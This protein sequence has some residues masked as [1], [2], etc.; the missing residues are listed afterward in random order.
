MLPRSQ[1]S[2]SWGRAFKKLGISSHTSLSQSDWLESR[3]RTW[4]SRRDWLV[5]NWFSTWLSCRDW[6]VESRFHMWLL[7]SPW[8]IGWQ[9]ILYVTVT[10]RPGLVEN[11]LAEK[12]DYYCPRRHAIYSSWSRYSTVTWIFLSNNWLYFLLT[13]PEYHRMNCLQS[14]LAKL[15]LIA[16]NCLECS[17]Y[18]TGTI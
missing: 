5:E 13:K 15:L 16:P 2:G 14:R 6:L 11:R 18:F 9:P 12:L 1:S 3:F 17:K 10:P 8:L 7:R 4:L